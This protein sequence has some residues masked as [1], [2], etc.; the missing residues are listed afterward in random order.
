MV[1]GKSGPSEGA[2]GH[3][4][5]GDLLGNLDQLTPPRLH[6]RIDGDVAYVRTDAGDG[7]PVGKLR[8]DGQGALHDLDGAGALRHLTADGVVP[9]AVH[10]NEDRLLYKSFRLP[11]SAAADLDGA[12]GF[13]IERHTPFRGQD[14]VYGC[15]TRDVPGDGRMLAADTVIAQRQ[16]LQPLLAGLEGRGLRAVRLLA[17]TDAGEV[18]LRIPAGLM[19]SSP[20]TIRRWPAIAAL[21]L[22]AA[23]FSPLI[24]LDR[25]TAG[26]VEQADRISGEIAVANHGAGVAGD[27]YPAVLELR[28][29]PTTLD[30]LDRLSAV[31]PDGTWLSG[32]NIAGERMEIEGL[33]DDSA[34]LVTLLN[35]S[36]AFTNVAYLAPVVADA[37][38]GRE[39]FAF[40]M[41]RVR[42]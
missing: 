32:L 42:P 34:R 40:S 36:P 12:I 13:E 10:L 9:V 38:G 28:R 3:R 4:A 6:V 21:A 30:S 31:L 14:V 15:R 20:R 37:G 22:L 24:W 11:K 5:V 26:L 2:G 29:N 23:A 25:Q 16:V 33:T 1:G 39:R 17:A 18:A 35:T 7:A 27:P 19:A 8:I 41:N